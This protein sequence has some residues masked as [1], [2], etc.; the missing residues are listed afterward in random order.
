MRLKVE[1]PMVLHVNRLHNIHDNG[2]DREFNRTA[3]PVSKLSTNQLIHSSAGWVNEYHTTNADS[4]DNYNIQQTQLRFG[5]QRSPAPSLADDEDDQHSSGSSSSDVSPDLEDYRSLSQSS[6]TESDVPRPP[7]G[8]P[9]SI[10]NPNYPGFDHFASQLLTPGSESEEDISLNNNNNNNNIN[11]DDTF[12][13]TFYD[14]P[15]FNTEELCDCDVTKQLNSLNIKEVEKNIQL[16]MELRM[17]EVKYAENKMADA[18]LSG[19]KEEIRKHE[20]NRVERKMEPRKIDKMEESLKK[21]KTVSQAAN[22]TTYTPPTNLALRSSAQRRS[23]DKKKTSPDI[24]SFDV[25]NIETAMP[26]IDLDAIEN[27]L[28]AAREEERRRRNDREEIRRRLATGDA[29][30]FYGG[31]RPGR[32]PSLQARL[33]SGMNLQI[34]FMNDQ[35]SDTESPSSDSETPAKLVSPMKQKQ[36]SPLSKTPETNKLSPSPNGLTNVGI[37]EMSEVD[38]L[39]CIARL[40]TEARTALAQASD[41]AHL[42][43]QI[44]RQRRSVS[45][46]TE[47]LRNTLHKVGV[48]FPQDRR[49]VSRQMLTDMNIAQLQVIANDLHAQIETLNESLVKFLMERDEL[50]MSQDSMLVDIEDLTRYLGAKENTFKED[51]SFNNNLHESKSKLP[52]NRTARIVRK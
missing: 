9:R 16:D 34:C 45:P 2:F 25:Y 6:D 27:H 24:G 28:K 1:S 37:A 44:E 19:V 14:K 12:E 13:K 36:P 11:E 43:M 20:D 52:A 7:S 39:V 29:D 46:I 35:M 42:Q 26:V 10:V 47:M 3:D 33:Q 31:D 21:V 30:E 41:L 17:D 4:N 5:K 18:F 8:N 51:I 50:H 49:R 15:K 22:I 32:K 23:R 48:V 38:V 40:Q